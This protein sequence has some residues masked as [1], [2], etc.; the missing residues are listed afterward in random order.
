MEYNDRFVNVPFP[1]LGS[2][3]INFQEKVLLSLIASF[4]DGD[5]YM[6]N[7]T[8]SKVMGVSSRT[9]QRAVRVLKEKGMIYSEIVIKDKVIQGRIITL[10]KSNGLIKKINRE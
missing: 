1:I 7:K 10:N 5:F 3:S 6:S 9:T 4:F 2:K 8:I